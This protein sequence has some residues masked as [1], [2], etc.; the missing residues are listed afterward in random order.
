[1]FRGVSTIP[2][3]KR[4]LPQMVGSAAKRSPLEDL[5]LERYLSE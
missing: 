3:M 2:I 1:M 4:I 5:A